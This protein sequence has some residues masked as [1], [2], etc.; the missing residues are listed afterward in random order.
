MQDRNPEDRLVV[1]VDQ[2]EEV[3]TLCQDEDERRALFGNLLYAATIPGGRVVVIL[4]MRADFYQRCA[5]YP[6]LRSLVARHQFL[7]GPLSNEA[8]REAI[9]LPARRV[10]LEFEAGLIQTISGPR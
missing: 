10:G 1:L 8:L 3:F 4:G 7:V 5:A 2:L 6:D 9:E